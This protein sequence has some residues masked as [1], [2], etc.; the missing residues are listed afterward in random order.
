MD[1]YIKA[2]LD[3]EVVKELKAGDMVHWNLN[4]ADFYPEFD[5]KV[6]V[7]GYDWNGNI[8]AYDREYKAVLKILEQAKNGDI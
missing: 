7:F 2:P 5:N 4:I 8:M 1:K 6:F 3:R